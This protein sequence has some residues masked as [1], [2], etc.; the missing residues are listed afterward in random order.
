[1]RRERDRVAL[2]Q[3]KSAIRGPKSEIGRP[4]PLAISVSRYAVHSP[5]S[6][7]GRM[8]ASAA[9]RGPPPHPAHRARPGGG[10]RRWLRDR[11]RRSPT[12]G[13]D[14]CGAATRHVPVAP[15]AGVVEKRIR[16]GVENLVRHRRGRRGFDRARLDSP[17]SMSA[18]TRRQ[19]I[20]VHGLV[21]AVVQRLVDE[22]MIRGLD[23]AGVIVPARHLR[24]KDRGEEILA[25]MR[26][27]GIGTRRPPLCRK[28]AR[29]RVT[30]QRQ[31]LVN[32]G[33]AS[34][35]WVRSASRRCARTMENT[36][37]RGKLCCSPSESTMRRQWPPPAVRSRR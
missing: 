3:R 13:P 21:Q 22:R 15:R 4:A 18:R 32:I 16:V 6:R 35:A 7:S 9:R 20:G 8:R 34:A 2:P 14:R 11:A 31:R 30:F 25:R 33:A 29:A 23:R 12:P 24:R 17:D 10:L 5:A 1:M 36:L 37:S 19:P 26:W 27:I 28:R